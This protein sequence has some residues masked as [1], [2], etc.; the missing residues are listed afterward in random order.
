M[1]EIMIDEMTEFPDNIPVYQPIPGKTSFEKR[2]FLK[3]PNDKCNGSNG[4]KPR[5]KT[6]KYE[7]EKWNPVIIHFKFFI[8]NS[9]QNFN[10]Q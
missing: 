5:Y 3:K 8:K 2:M 1:R 10:D 4:N 7:N 9:P 6:V